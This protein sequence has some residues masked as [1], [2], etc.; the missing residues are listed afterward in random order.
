[1]SE[2]NLDPSKN[3]TTSTTDQS[4]NNSNIDI[5]LRSLNEGVEAVLRQVNYSDE[6]NQ[7]PKK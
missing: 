1:M 7:N 5:G 4:Q 3:I 2:K 6:K